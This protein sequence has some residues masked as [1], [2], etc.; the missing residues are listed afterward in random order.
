MVRHPPR[1]TR[2]GGE[3]DHRRGDAVPSSQPSPLGRRSR[4]SCRAS[5]ECPPS[6][7]PAQAGIQVATDGP[8]SSAPPRARPSSPSV[9]F[10]RPH[11]PAPHR[12]S[13]N[14]RH[15]Y[16]R[17]PNAARPTDGHDVG[18]DVPSS[19]PSPLGRRSRTSRGVSG[20]CAPLRHSGGSRN[21]GSDRWSVILRA[22][23][24]TGEKPTTCAAVASPHPTLLPRGEGAGRAAG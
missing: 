17:R 9:P 3:A 5:G 2:Y 18:G 10:A 12:P 8:S 13:A 4:T 20:E 21:P 16:I 15:I 19:H 7:I 23:L 11:P 6:V 24:D 22:V 1:C 14:P